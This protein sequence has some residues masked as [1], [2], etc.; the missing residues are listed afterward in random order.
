[1]SN[2]SNNNGRGFEYITLK[3]FEG[4]ISKICKVEVDETRGYLATKSAWDSLSDDIK[5]R[6]QKSALVAVEIV[7][8]LEPLIID[9]GNDPVLLRIQTDQAGKMGDV[10]DI[11]IERPGIEWVIGLSL[12]HNHSAVKH[13]RLS[14]SID[15]GNQWF[16]IPC[17]KNYW[18]ALQRLRIRD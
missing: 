2:Q 8:G 14:D 17:S 5:K 10:R 18:S 7:L 6:L 12:K 15:F 13:S 11:V 1:M 9:E 16:R 3:T 4:E